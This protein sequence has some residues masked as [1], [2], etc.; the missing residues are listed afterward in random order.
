M[1]KNKI[2]IEDKVNFMLDKNANLH[3]KSMGKWISKEFNEKDNIIEDLTRKVNKLKTKI[4]L[5]AGK[6]RQL[7]M[8]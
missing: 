4:V 8:F 7:T 2:K 6:D 3:K 1:K 5:A